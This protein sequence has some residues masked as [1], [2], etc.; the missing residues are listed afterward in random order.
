MATTPAHKRISK[1]DLKTDAFTTSIFAA[2]EWAEENV[3][4]IA[5][6]IGAMVIL[7][8]A[9]WGFSSYRANEQLAAQSLYGEAGVE[10]RSNN[11]SVAIALLQRLVDEHGGAQH[12]GPASI[13]LGQLHF[14]ERSFDEARLA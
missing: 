1:K 13:Q 6:V 2:K 14:Q 9:V 8:A 11:N 4:M 5:I 12:A 3:R 10:I 7:V